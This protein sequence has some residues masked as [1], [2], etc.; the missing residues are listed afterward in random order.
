M[1]NLFAI[2]LHLLRTPFT[3][4]WYVAGLL[5]VLSALSLPAEPKTYVP[6]RPPIE[7]LRLGMSADSAEIVFRTVAKR[8]QSMRLDSL[9]L[10][11]SDSVMVF[12]QPAYVQLQMLRRKVRTI[13]VNFHP[14]GGGEYIDTRNALS[15]YM[16]KFFGRG[17][18]TKDE[19]VTHRRWETEDGT[20]EVSYSDK[21]YRLF[22]RLGKH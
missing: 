2:T 12:G 6:P 22:V 13:V 21:Y 8:R 3:N 15:S 10:L 17:V 16:E 1:R 9:E 4:A 7:G 11:E 20:H 18:I 14:L 19:S 5:L